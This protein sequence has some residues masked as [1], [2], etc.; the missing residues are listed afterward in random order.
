[1]EQLSTLATAVES[2]VQVDGKVVTSRGPG[3]TMEYAV[4]L[5][6][7]LFGKEKAGEVAGP[8]VYVSS[9]N[10]IFANVVFSVPLLCYAL[11]EK[12]K[13]LC[14]SNGSIPISILN[15]SV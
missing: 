8:L 4:T 1:M 9:L 14:R 15:L 2:R 6:E 13:N 11:L 12:L 10:F 3:T 7:Q 5:V